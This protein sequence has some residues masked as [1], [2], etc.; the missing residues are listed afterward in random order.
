MSSTGAIPKIFNYPSI[1]EVFPSDHDT[2]AE[3][4]AYSAQSE[5]NWEYEVEWQYGDSELQN[6]YHD[7]PITFSS[8]S[9]INFLFFRAMY[10]ISTRL[11]VSFTAHA[12]K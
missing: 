6:H 1:V 5:R 4:L 10:A 12:E 3:D 11:V 9:W 7:G 2:F 8:E